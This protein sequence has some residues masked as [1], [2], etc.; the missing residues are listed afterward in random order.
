MEVDQNELA[1]ALKAA[2]DELKHTIKRN[3]S[4]RVVEGLEEEIELLGRVPVSEVEEAQHSILQTA[5]EME[6]QEKIVLSRSAEE[7]MVG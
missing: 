1:L 6:K 5:Q 2:S 3:L 4:E 7:S